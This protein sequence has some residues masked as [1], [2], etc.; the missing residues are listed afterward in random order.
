MRPSGRVIREDA[1]AVFPAYRADVRS[2]PEDWRAWYRLGARL[3]RG[4]RPAACREAVRQAIRSRPPNAEA[5]PRW[6]RHRRIRSLLDGRVGEGEARRFENRRKDR[7]VAREKPL[8][9]VGAEAQLH[10]PDRRP[11][12]ER[13]VHAH[14]EGESEVVRGRAG[15]SREVHRTGESS[16]MTWRIAAHLVVERDPRPHLGATADRPAETR[17][18][19]AAAAA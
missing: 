9:R 14:R 11:Q 8:G 18:P 1:D 15:R 10:A 12:Q 13:P 19:S 3:R 17:R 7:S 6:R 2:T 5:N 4:R 16:S